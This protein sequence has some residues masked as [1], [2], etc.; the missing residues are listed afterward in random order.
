MSRRALLRPGAAAAPR[1]PPARGGARTGRD[2]RDVEGVEHA[3]VAG[4]P[5]ERRIVYGY[6]FPSCPDRIKI[7][8]SARGLARIVEQSTG[9]PEK[10]ILLF[11]IHDARAKEVERAFHAA[12]AHRR[13]NTLGVEW[14][15]ATLAEVVAVS[16]HLR[17]ALGRR[18]GGLRRRALV[19]LFG[20]TAGLALA[21]VA[22]AVAALLFE[23]GLPRDEAVSSLHAALAA[24]TSPARDALEATL[25]TL[26]AVA[27]DELSLA[28]AI[29]ALA[30]AFLLA[31]LPWRRRALPTPRVRGWRDGAVARRRTGVFLASAALGLAGALWALP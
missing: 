10:P 5:R 6:G 1:R 31:L 29:G 22:S 23:P 15:E 24:L 20:A 19:S 12:L 28:V 17:R 9:F 18:R 25:G 11:M 26:G 7:G 16:P 13:A 4:D 3:I 14:F 2:R 8:Y 27:A 21:P 30:P